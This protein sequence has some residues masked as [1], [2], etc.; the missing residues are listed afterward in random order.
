[1]ACVSRPC[2]RDG[3]WFSSDDMHLARPRACDLPMAA[4]SSAGR[5]SDLMRTCSLLV[6]TLPTRSR[7]HA[8][9]RPRGAC[10][11]RGTSA[12][13]VEPR[14]DSCCEPG[15]GAQA[16]RDRHLRG[17][18]P[19]GMGRKG[20]KCGALRISAAPKKVRAVCARDVLKHLPASRTVKCD[21]TDVRVMRTSSRANSSRNG[22]GRTLAGPA[23]FPTRSRPQFS[24]GASAGL[25]RRVRPP[26]RSA[27]PARVRRA[28]T[29]GRWPDGSSG[30]RA[31]I[32]ASSPRRARRSPW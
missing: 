11:C 22:Q 30:V 10:S 12:R 18:R 4:Q 26:T 13:R 16:V 14:L 15:S 2:A 23:L 9:G 32:A 19:P 24:V 3:R 21:V 20:F 8:S 28:A 17:S 27:R 25:R 7:G 29:S 31:R 1:M 5:A 6:P